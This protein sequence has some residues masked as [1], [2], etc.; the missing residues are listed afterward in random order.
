MGS[1]EEVDISVIKR[2]MELEVYG[3]GLFLAPALL[4]GLEISFGDDA[5]VASFFSVFN[6][7]G[8]MSHGNM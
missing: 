6:G 2:A 5:A 1:L 8:G 4:A 3:K 7:R